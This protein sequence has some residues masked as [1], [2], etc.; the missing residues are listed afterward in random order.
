MPERIPLFRTRRRP[1]GIVQKRCPK[2]GR[3][4]FTSNFGQISAIDTTCKAWGCAVCG[5]RKIYTWTRKLE[6]VLVELSDLNLITFTFATGNERCQDAS[7]VRTVHA[8]FLKLFR[9][10]LNLRMEHLTVPELTKNNIPHLHSVTATKNI[11]GSFSQIRC[12]PLW[13]NRYN[14]RWL[15]KDCLCLHH[16]VCR[17]WYEVVKDS[18]VV[19]VRPIRLG[20]GKGISLYLGKYLM[21]ACF[22]SV[23][24]SLRAMGFERRWS[25]SRGFPW[26]SVN[27][28]G[29]ADNEDAWNSQEF[30]RRGVLNDQMSNIVEASKRLPQFKI[31]SSESFMR[32]ARV[33]EARKRQ[34]KV[35]KLKKGG[36]Q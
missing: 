34:K 2:A 1:D 9:N 7:Y 36:I 24:D 12:E 30:I 22:G 26:P 23:R 19:D 35:E 14:L 11:S 17:L 3:V 13:W 15:R 32:L 29:S 20:T 16:Y 4:M 25:R 10:R 28:R 5:K 6:S 21:K 33:G 18:Y 27:L 31:V 8:R